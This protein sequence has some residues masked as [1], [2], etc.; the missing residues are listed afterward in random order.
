MPDLTPEQ[1]A[2]IVWLETWVRW[3][4]TAYYQ[5]DDC[6]TDAEFDRRAVQLRSLLPESLVF[7]TGWGY[8]PGVAAPKPQ[9]EMP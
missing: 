8:V 1:R 5:G 6:P 7:V 9:G 3:A 4:A 2:R